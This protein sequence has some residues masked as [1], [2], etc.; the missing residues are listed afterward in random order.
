MLLNA[1]FNTA[2]CQ[3]SYYCMPRVPVVNEPEAACSRIECQHLN[4]RFNESLEKLPSMLLA[5]TPD[6]E[7]GSVDAVSEPLLLLAQDDFKSLS[8]A[9]SLLERSREV[10]PLPVWS[11]GTRCAE[12]D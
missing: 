6:N 9:L 11:W 7:L 4:V 2:N 8:P 5:L 3:I 10:C 12:T 1:R